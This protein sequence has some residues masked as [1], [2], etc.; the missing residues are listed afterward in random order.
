MQRA[1]CLHQISISLMLFW[2][3]GGSYLFDRYLSLHTRSLNSLCR[4]V[5]LAQTVF[6]LC[7]QR[8]VEVP[9]RLHSPHPPSKASA[10]TFNSTTW[11][12]RSENSLRTSRLG[13]FFSFSSFS[14]ADQEAVSQFATFLLGMEALAPQKRPLFVLLALA[15]VTAAILDIAMLCA[16]EVAQCKTRESP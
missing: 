1:S 10:R 13:T 11:W 9:H 15:G 8:A 2:C 6:L 14:I 16:E 3:Y 7:R 4:L 12:L 5:I